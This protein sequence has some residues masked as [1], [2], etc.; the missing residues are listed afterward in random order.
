[1]TFT[2]RRESELEATFADWEHLTVGVGGHVGTEVQQGW[3]DLFDLHCDRNWRED[4][5]SGIESED[6]E[7]LVA[8]P[9]TSHQLKR[10]GRNN[11]KARWRLEACADCWEGRNA[12][13]ALTCFDTHFLA[14]GREAFSEGHKNRFSGQGRAGK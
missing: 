8:E 4:S 14:F 2:D 1:M 11:N 7:S 9:L 12:E 13:H 10:L 3:R 6:H 5:A